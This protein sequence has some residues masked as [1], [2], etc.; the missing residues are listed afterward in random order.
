VV[1]NGKTEKSRESG[2]KRSSSRERSVQV[3]FCAVNVLLNLGC[4]RFFR[5]EGA[6]CTQKVQKGDRDL[7]AVKISVEIKKI[8]LAAYV[9]VIIREGRTHA[10]VA[11]A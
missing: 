8:S 9:L 1:K 3:F 4:Q 10:H 7:L 11:N 5:R 2:R 6:F